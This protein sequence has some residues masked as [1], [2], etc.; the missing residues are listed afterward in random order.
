MFDPNDYPETQRE[1]EAAQRAEALGDYEEGRSAYDRMIGSPV[2]EAL[3]GWRRAMRIAA[4]IQNE[5]E[6]GA[7]TNTEREAA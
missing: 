3:N 2:G 5:V 4:R 6:L 7:A 1:Y